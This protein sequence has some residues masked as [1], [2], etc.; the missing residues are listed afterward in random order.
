ML[1][2]IYRLITNINMKTTINIPDELWSKFCIKVINEEGKARKNSSVL[3]K[4][5]DGYVKQK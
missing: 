1:W 4:L 2:Y 5:I 3:I